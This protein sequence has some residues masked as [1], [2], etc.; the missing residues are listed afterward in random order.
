MSIL[1]NRWR[2]R[3]VAA[4]L[5]Q[6]GILRKDGSGRWVAPALTPD[7]TDE[8]YEL[9]WLLEPVAMEKAVPHL[10]PGFLDVMEDE[11]RQAIK[12]GWAAPVV[13]SGLCVSR[14]VPFRG[15]SGEHSRPG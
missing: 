11:L 15:C 5:H 8:L 14:R 13:R 12:R 6:R 10:P 9:R 1:W 3:E 2:A 7:Y 4:R